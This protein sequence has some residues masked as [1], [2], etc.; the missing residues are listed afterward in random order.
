M[1]RRGDDGYVVHVSSM[2]AYRIPPGGGAYA[3][4]K[5]AVRALTEGLRQELRQAGSGIR[6]TAISPG[7]VETEFA[8][9]FHGDEE[10]GR[11]TY[12][13]FPVLQADDIAKAVHFVLSQPPHVQFHDLLLRPTQQPN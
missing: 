13:R 5:F 7:F 9:I 1:R 11:Q 10:R 2:A 4:T 6:V 8:G 12:G 3:A